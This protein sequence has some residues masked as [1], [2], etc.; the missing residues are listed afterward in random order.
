MGS[1][2]GDTSD[3]TDSECYLLYL[4]VS[5]RSVFVSMEGDWDEDGVFELGIEG[6]GFESST[7]HREEEPRQESLGVFVLC[8]VQDGADMLHVAEDR[9]WRTDATRAWAEW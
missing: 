8:M 4:I 7:S 6:E 2:H 5:S 9:K 3:V 1:I